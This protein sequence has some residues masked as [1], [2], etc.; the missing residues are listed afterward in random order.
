[1]RGMQERNTRL[2]LIVPLTNFTHRK[3]SS[4]LD[5]FLA[6]VWLLIGWLGF[7]NQLH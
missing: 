3:M 2:I 6:I 5:M 7:K 1:M 4:V